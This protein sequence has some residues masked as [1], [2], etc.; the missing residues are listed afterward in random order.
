[1]NKHKKTINEI[2]KGHAAITPET[3]LELERTLGIDANFWLEKKG[4]IS[5]N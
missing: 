2:V 3:A 5:Y 4:D 1:M